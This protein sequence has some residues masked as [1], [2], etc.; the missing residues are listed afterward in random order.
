M[1][2]SSTDGKDAASVS[3]HLEGISQPQKLADVLPVSD[4]PWYKT[5]HLVRLNICLLIPLISSYV[6]GFDGSMLNGMQS[7]PAWIEGSSL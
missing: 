6:T 1:P 4:K 7:V 3:A 2:S 5:P